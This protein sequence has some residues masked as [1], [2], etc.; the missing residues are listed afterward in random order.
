MLKKIR[1]EKTFKSNVKAGVK[2]ALEHL[3]KNDVNKGE[4]EAAW[5]DE[6]IQRKKEEIENGVEGEEDPEESKATNYYST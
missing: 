4:Q 3:K 2:E 6:L 1:E 5:I